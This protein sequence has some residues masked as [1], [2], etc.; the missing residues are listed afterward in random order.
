[1]PQQETSLHEFNT[2]E[3]LRVV[4]EA[5]AGF[6]RSLGAR[7]TSGYFSIM[8]DRGIYGKAFENCN[9][10]GLIPQ[11]T[12]KWNCPSFHHIVLKVYHSAINMGLVIPHAPHQELDW[13]QA[14]GAFHFT[15]EGIRY[16]SEGFISID[17]PGYLGEALLELKRRTDYIEDGQIELLLEAQRCFKS[18]CFRAGMVVIGVACEDACLGLLD[19]IP[20]NC[21]APASGSTLYGDWS[22]YCNVT[23]A[24]CRYAD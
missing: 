19:A 1:M 9:T 6:S 20:I 24:F 8:G 17:D 14:N 21:Q 13:N 12:D 5:F 11:H 7:N 10:E 18:G 4:W 22:S 3:I 23:L 15:D 2:T 16:F